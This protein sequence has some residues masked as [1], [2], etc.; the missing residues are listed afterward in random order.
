MTNKPLEAARK[1]LKRGWRVLPV[2]PGQKGTHISE[3]Q[4]LRLIADDLEHYFKPD[5][6]IGI[7]LGECSRDLTDVDCDTPE[8][9][10][11][12]HSL[13]PA[14]LLSGRGSNISHFWYTCTAAKSQKFKDLDG[15]V[16]LEIRHDEHQTVV[17]PSIHPSG[18]TY[19]WVNDMD[20]REIKAEKLY[21]LCHKVAAATLIGRHLPTGGRHDIALALA[22]WLLKKLDEYEVLEILEAA[23]KTQSVGSDALK[24]LHSIVSDTKEKLD[25]G[26]PIVGKRTLDE[27]LPGLSQRINQ[28]FGWKGEPADATARTDYGN[29][30]RFVARYGGDVKFVWEWKKW[31]FWNGK[32]WEKDEIGYVKHLATEAV[33][34]LYLE[35]AVAPS[36][37]AGKLAKHALGSLQHGKVESMLKMAASE[38]GMTI[39]ADRFDS[40]DHLLNCENGTLDLFA[41]KLLPHDKQDFITRL[42]PVPYRPAAKSPRFTR[43]MKEIL[44][45]GDTRDFVHKA[46]GY[47]LTGDVSERSL[48]IAQGPGNNGKS[49]LLNACADVLGDYAARANAE[50]FLEKPAGSIPNDVAQLKGPRLVL[51]SEVENGKRLSEAQVKNFTG[52]SDKLVGRFLYGE[53]F[54]FYPKFTA[55]IL[56]NPLPRIK[57]TDPAIWNRLRIIP[58]H[59][60]PAK[61]DLKLPKTLQREAEGIL[62]WMVAGFQMYRKHG[63]KS[64]VEVESMKQH[65][66]IDQD[67]IARFVAETCERGA[68]YSALLDELFSEFKDWAVDSEEWKISK[69]RFS[70]RLDDLHCGTV[71]RGRKTYKTTI[72][73]REDSG[74]DGGGGHAADGPQP[75]EVGGNAVLHKKGVVGAS[76]NG[77]DADNTPGVPVGADVGRNS[78]PVDVPTVPDEVAG[79]ILADSQVQHGSGELDVAYL[80]NI[81]PGSM[82]IWAIDT[83]TTGLDPRSSKLRVLSTTNRSRGDVGEPQAF[84]LDKEYELAEAHLLRITTSKVPVVFHNAAFDLAFLEQRFPGTIQQL[85]GRVYDTMILSQLAYAGQSVPPLKGFRTGHSLEACCERELG[86][87][88]DKGEQASD[89][90][91]SLTRSQL[92]YAARDTEHLPA[93]LGALAGKCNAA[94]VSDK[95]IR[96][97]MDLTPHLVTMRGRGLQVD[98]EGWKKKA[99]ESQDTVVGCEVLLVEKL[100]ELVDEDFAEDLPELNWGSPKQ[101]QFAFAEAGVFLEDTKDA[102]L[103]NSDDEFGLFDLLRQHRKANKLANSYGENWLEHVD[104]DGFIHPEWKQTSTDTGRMACANPNVQQIPRD[105][106]FRSLFTA[107]DGY[108]FVV[109]DYSQIE[110]RIAAK[111]AKDPVMLE[112]YR[113]G[114]DIHTLTAAAI[115]GKVTPTKED[116]QLAK[117]VNFGLLY[118]MGAAK[119][120]TYAKTEYGV[121]LSDEDAAKYRNR[122]LN[123]Y[124]FI[125]SWHKREGSKLRSALAGRD[126]ETLS[127][128]TLSGR[129]R[130]KVDLYTERLNTPVQGSGA[131]GIKAAL[132]KVARRELYHPV[133]VVHDELV[134]EVPADGDEQQYKQDIEQIMVDEMEAMINVKGK[135]VPVEV[136][137]KLTSRWEK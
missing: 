97:E 47:S 105:A 114:D 96:L 60:I 26:E 54:E 137:G 34:S 117:A 30:Q 13:L 17:E 12:A 115:T 132:L 124:Q 25:L 20:P 49:T 14:T 92:D 134:V 131:D 5:S 128:K 77:A 8:A 6:N 83:E 10:S 44:P 113:R 64:P 118:G 27:Y 29:G 129:V 46:I 110:L 85:E 90:G 43:F 35:A 80:R 103:A 57:G 98:V 133:A 82:D 19:R 42:V 107:R 86:I 52:G 100:T 72:R 63:L 39:S 91:G 81:D 15:S 50:V 24:D 70:S 112:A 33:R 127:V 111:I 120:R 11:C 21:D 53:H 102:T 51:A 45:D 125:R 116:R 122:W 74:D 66:R 56:T 71:V 16:L 99:E 94:G 119:L 65:Y 69:N 59:T 36:E 87:S 61:I 22:G 101:I 93:L 106:D 121:T 58:F 78:E 130:G 55:W 109:A 135:A 28:W 67:V 2:A 136:E 18:D 75:P 41:N 48:F 123:T 37:E 23:W 62:A 76:S 68:G 89:W 84:D 40:N 38:P 95:I 126:G 4:N 3:W 31:A 73:F 1:Y 104:Q 32:R 79:G 7:L 88:L 9:I 108:K